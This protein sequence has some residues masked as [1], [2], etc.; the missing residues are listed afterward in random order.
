MKE[1]PSSKKLCL[2]LF[3]FFS[4]TMSLTLFSSSSEQSAISTQLTGIT[5]VITGK[6][7]FVVPPDTPPGKTW[8]YQVGLP[9][10]VSA[11]EAAVFCNVRESLYEGIDFEVGV[12][13]IIFSD[14]S[15]MGGARP[16][17]VIRNHVEI[18]PNSIPSGKRATMVKYPMRGGFVPLGAKLENGTLHPYMGT[19]FGLGL[20]LAWNSDDPDVS[21]EFRGGSYR[22]GPPWGIFRFQG[23][24]AYGYWELSE[25]SYDGS[26]FTVTGTERVKYDE[27]LPGWRITNGGISNAIPDGSDLLLGMV[28]EK[29]G[30]GER[31]SGAGSGVMRWRFNGR[32]WRP[33]SFVM[34][35]GSDGSF[36]PSLIRD[37]DGKLLFLARGGNDALHDIRIWASDDNGQ[38]WTKTI[39]ANGL[40]A[41]SPISLNR[42]ADGTPFVAANLYEV[43]KSAAPMP[44]IYKDSEGWPILGGKGRNTMCI[45]PLNEERT[46]LKDAIV[47]RDCEA[48]FGPPVGSGWRVDHPVG[49][50]VRLADGNWHTILVMR[51]LDYA[52]LTFEMPPTARTGTYLEEVLTS[53][54]P[55]PIWDFE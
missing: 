23:E 41:G 24:E 4:N 53:G 36:E 30:S 32:Q 8:V 13:V 2:A 15:L 29:I 34:V 1:L 21:S 19:G 37:V 52:E 9:F 28:G 20:A 27:L 22:D 38:T 11:E 10:Q 16:T 3:I 12:D 44:V 31:G 55:L 26:N 35:P 46:A 7:V 47:V 45:W 39:Q 48:E 42:A 40:V 43:A 14:L 17:A 49:L 6:R 51:V 54:P 25:F 33:I 18:N 5:E 50:P